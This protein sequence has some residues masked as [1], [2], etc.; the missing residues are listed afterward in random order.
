MQEKMFIKSDFDPTRAAE[1]SPPLLNTATATTSS[2]HKVRMPWKK[3]GFK[4]A[5]CTKTST[6]APN[7]AIVGHV[8]CNE[9]KE[10]Q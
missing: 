10:H 6:Q 8:S 4:V 7:E 3:M 1:K 9:R 2:I 5:V